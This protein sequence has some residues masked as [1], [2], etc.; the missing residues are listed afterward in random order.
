MYIHTPFLRSKFVSKKNNKVVKYRRGFNLNIGFIVF[1]VIII[2][3]IFHLFTYFTSKPVSEYEVQQGTIATNNI[4]KGL[5]LRQESVVYAEESGSLNYYAANGSKVSTKDVVYSVD[6]DGS[7][8]SQITGAQSDASAMTDETADDIISDINSFS[9]SYNSQNF[10]KVYT[11]KNNL[12]STLTQVLSQSALTNLGDT[13]SSA[14]ANNTFYTFNPSSSGIVYYGLDGYEEITTDNF[15]LDQY[16]N[17]SYEETDLS[18][19]TSINQ[20]DPVYKLITSEN[21]YILINVSDKVAESLNEKSV[22]KIRFCDDDFT[23]TVSFD[24]IKKDDQYFLKLNLKNSL[25]RYVNERFTNIEL[26][27]SSDTGL[28]IPNSA[29]TTKEFFTIP[30]QYFTESGDS[31]DLCVM[32]QQPSSD[33]VTIVN[34]TIFSENDD[35]YFVDDEDLSEGD[36]LV[37][38]DS[39]TTYTVGTDKDKL[40]GVYNINKGYAVF[41]QIKI[42]SENDDYSIV[43]TKTSYGIA[44]YDH[45]ALDGS[46]VV[47]NQ[48][49]TK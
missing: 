27:L 30:K 21:W 2:Y 12:S 34:P 8:S 14:E 43:E 44:L 32:V 47:E 26:V 25:I 11:F 37:M 5:I 18:Q 35:Y 13:I 29:I 38:T 46:S 17:T 36:K 7:I 41:K 48:T 9:S 6:T 22:V 24:I 40:I 31:S 15:T 23:T 3:V 19:N 33:S 20:L 4:Y 45:I 10:Y 42:L 1:F 16:N 39:S 49:I 28:K